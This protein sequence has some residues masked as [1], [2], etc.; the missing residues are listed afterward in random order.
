MKRYVNSLLFWGDYTFSKYPNVKK[1]ESK[2][3][4]LVRDSQFE[5]KVQEQILLFKE[6]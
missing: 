2:V 5:Q 1:K 4:N 6:P 3:L